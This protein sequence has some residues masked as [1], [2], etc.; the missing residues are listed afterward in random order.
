MEPKPI[1]QNSMA[2]LVFLLLSYCPVWDAQAVPGRA[3]AQTPAK[4]QSGSRPGPT[5]GKAAQAQP[6]SS[7][8]PVEA[9]DGSESDYPPC[10]W[11]PVL[12]YAII[13]SHNPD[14][15]EALLDAAFAAG[16]GIVPQ[17][18]ASL[19]DDR[20]AEF[21]AKAIAFIGGDQEIPILASLLQDKRDLDLRRFYCGALGEFNDPR[22]AQILL[23]ALDRAN[24]ED[25]RAV[26][27]AAILALTVRSNPG[28]IK[29]MQ[30]AEAKMTDPV[31]QDDVE[32][33]LDAIR[34]RAK[35]LTTPQGKRAGGSI[36]EAIR[37][38]FIP[39]LLPQVPTTKTAKHLKPVL[40]NAKFR[41]DRLVLSPNQQRALAHV[42]LEDPAAV[43]AYDIVLQKESG[44]WTVA[45]VWLGR[46]REK[47]LTPAK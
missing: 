21:A 47:Q 16:P 46:E 39:A 18:K 38:Y 22:A 19:V 41:V 9:Q 31:L 26:T 43:A 44:N 20:T 14:A 11:A 10:E 1:L 5:T 4:A 2:V 32:N 25:D 42:T 24:Q 29:P 28:L 15:H 12:L 27:E 45:S 40:P 23:Y 13:S 3:Q 37:T 30:Q 7:P 8:C 17:L 6:G 34:V 35:Y 36:A 33:A